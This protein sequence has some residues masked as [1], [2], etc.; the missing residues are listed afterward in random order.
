MR[1]SED[2]SRKKGSGRT[3]TRLQFVLAVTKLVEIE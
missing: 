3:L 2:I 1:G